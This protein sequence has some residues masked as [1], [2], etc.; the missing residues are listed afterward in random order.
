MLS[1]TVFHAIVQGRSQ[2]YASRV[3]QYIFIQHVLLVDGCDTFVPQ[4]TVYMRVRLRMCVDARACVCVCSRLSSGV[5]WCDQLH[6]CIMHTCITWPHLH[7]GVWLARAHIS[8]EAGTLVGADSVCTFGV[9]VTNARCLGVLW[10]ALVYVHTGGAAAAVAT[11]AGADKGALRVAALRVGVA[12]VR[13]RT[14]LIHI[15]TGHTITRESCVAGALEAALRVAA[16]GAAVAVVRVD[17]GAALVDVR[18][19]D[20]VAIVAGE[21]FTDEAARRVDAA[22]IVA[23]ALVVAALIHVKALYAIACVP[24]NT[25]A[26]ESARSTVDRKQMRKWSLPTT[27][28]V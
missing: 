17:G 19:R 25:C 3:H 24:L 12:V 20:P 27:D 22:P 13:S 23:A 9:L 26:H 28:S 7:A 21:A 18:A 1:V 11:F 4:R 10:F 14:A 8:H 2:P 6:A 5:C 15:Q 16:C